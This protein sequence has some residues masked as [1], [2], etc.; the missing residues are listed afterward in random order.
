VTS[1]TT[2]YTTLLV[3]SICPQ[4]LNLCFSWNYPFWSDILVF[5][6]RR[7]VYPGGLKKF[8][9]PVSFL[10]NLGPLAVGSQANLNRISDSYKIV[11]AQ[12]C[13]YLIYFKHW[14]RYVRRRYYSQKLS[15]QAEPKLTCKLGPK[16]PSAYISQ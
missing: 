8:T 3:D 7:G 2:V 15:T 5:I 6:F 14:Q 1:R 4:M 13:L 10:K 11:L 16:F 9:D 12:Q